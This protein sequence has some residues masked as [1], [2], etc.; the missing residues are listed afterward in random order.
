MDN[1]KGCNLRGKKLDSIKV[2]SKY[3]VPQWTTYLS[4]Q[5]HSAKLWAVQPS[6]GR[7]PATPRR[8]QIKSTWISSQTSMSNSSSWQMLSQGKKAQ[9]RSEFLKQLANRLVWSYPRQGSHLP[10][11]NLAKN[12]FRS[13]ARSRCLLLVREVNRSKTLASLALPSSYTPKRA[14]LPLIKPRWFQKCRSP[15]HKPL[16]TNNSG[17]NSKSSLINK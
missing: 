8:W 12:L 9:H 14:E 2:G 1:L 10:E 16:K 13:P 17:L 5:S 3:L 11:V 7:D 6:S 4:R 15:S